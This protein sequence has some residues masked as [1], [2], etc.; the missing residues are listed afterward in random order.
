MFEIFIPLM[1]Q[2]QY[3]PLE[4]TEDDVRAL[5]A[6]II[7]TISFIHVNVHDLDS[8]TSGTMKF[9]HIDS[10]LKNNVSTL[11]PSHVSNQVSIRPDVISI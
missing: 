11:V 3:L 8:F 5:V 2:N 9:E 1:P 6:P 7:Q 10:S 4:T